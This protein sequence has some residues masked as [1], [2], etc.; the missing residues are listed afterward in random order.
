MT[1]SGNSFMTPAAAAFIRSSARRSF[2]FSKLYLAVNLRHKADERRF[3]REKFPVF[4]KEFMQSRKP[5]NRVSNAKVLFKKGL[6]SEE[7]VKV[8]K[9]RKR[10]EISYLW[11][12]LPSILTTIQVFGSKTSS[13]SKLRT[14]S[15]LHARQLIYHWT[16]LI[17]RICTLNLPS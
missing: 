13:C 15:Y 11:N 8:K 12:P 14:Y 9:H 7:N 17:L 3:P 10:E 4:L 16:V 6:S 5:A 2:G 1:K